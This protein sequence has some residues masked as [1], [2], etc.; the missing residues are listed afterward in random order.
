MSCQNIVQDWAFDQ[1]SRIVIPDKRSLQ[2]SVCRLAGLEYQE[3]FNQELA[4]K[5]FRIISASKKTEE[6][7]HIMVEE[8]GLTVSGSFPNLTRSRGSYRI[9]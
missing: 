4:E 6:L 9:L 5:A 8:A 1:M 3:P 2:E 7:K